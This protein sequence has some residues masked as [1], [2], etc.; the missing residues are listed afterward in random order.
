MTEKTQRKL[1]E[2]VELLN[3]LDVDYA[4]G[5]YRDLLYAHVEKIWV[6]VY[7]IRNEFYGVDA[8]DDEATND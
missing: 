7:V 1:K 8:P 4:S 5:E 6:V 2:L 3:A